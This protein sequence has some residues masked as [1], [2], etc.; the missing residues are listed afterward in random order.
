M[1]GCVK[2]GQMRPILHIDMDAFFSPVEKKR[3]P[4]QI[5]KPVAACEE[6]LGRGTKDRG[7]SEGENGDQDNWRTF[8]PV[9]GEI[10]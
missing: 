5:G 8:V 7:V 2:I 4:E 1:P 10:G 3:H 9:R 6:A